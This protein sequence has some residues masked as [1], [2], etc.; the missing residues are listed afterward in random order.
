MERAD[1][2]VPSSPGSPAGERAGRYEIF[3]EIGS[4]GMARVH[5]GR[6][7]GAAGFA[8]TVAIKRPLPALTRDE[9]FRRSASNEARLA[10]R[11][12]HPNVVP[13]LD[14]VEH[15]DELLIVME[16]VHGESLA[17]LAAAAS[18]RGE[19]VP[20]DVASA[21]VV[22]AL[23]GLEAVHAARDERGRPLGLIHRDVSPQNILV[24]ADGLPRLSDFGLAK[25]AGHANATGRD[26]FKGK[27]TYASPEQVALQPLTPATDLYSMGLV[28][29]ELL[30]GTRLYAGL[31]AAEVVGRLL[32]GGAVLTP[33]RAAS[34]VPPVL[35]G[36]VERATKQRPGDRYASAAAM[37]E[38]LARR[39][40]PASPA[41]V[42]AWVRALASRS[43]AERERLVMAAERQTTPSRRGEALAAPGPDAPPKI[44]TPLPREAPSSFELAVT[45]PVGPVMSRSSP[46]GAAPPAGGPGTTLA[47]AGPALA[48]APPGLA[49]EQTPASA[50]KPFAVFEG[51]PRAAPAP[52]RPS[53][54]GVAL[55]ASG[56]LVGASLAFAGANAVLPRSVPSKPPAPTASPSPLFRSPEPSS[57]APAGAAPAA[58]ANPEGVAP[59]AAA[60][61]EGAASPPAGTTTEGT[62]PPAP[63]TTTEGA[64]PPAP[65]TTTEGAAPAVAGMGARP[66]SPTAPPP[67]RSPEL[68]REGERPAPR[69]EGE[70]PGPKRENCSPPYSIDADGIRHMKP[71]C[72]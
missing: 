13:T 33:S 59:A 9:D 68:H 28:L 65:G 12:H 25:A 61:P 8:R 72:Q 16:Y 54:G 43:L 69:R 70:R 6:L 41:E 24:G 21:L 55:R 34:G 4:G 49:R 22:G 29:W 48:P 60:N 46:A 38:A 1:L 39:V 52:S 31:T 36:V 44:S 58:A 11:V 53:F 67:K 47:S 57:R 35:D 30:V 64:A 51:A 20:L 42:A 26:E 23:R 62:A 15:G 14:V 3:A 7:L 40:E 66:V 56:V 5:V 63:G 50:P 18:Q 71:G 2:D 19:R 27:L 37:A 17:A 45:M 32:A 10:A